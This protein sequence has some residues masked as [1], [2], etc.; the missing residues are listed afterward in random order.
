MVGFVAEKATARKANQ[1][2]TGAIS[3][4]NSMLDSLLLN[5]DTLCHIDMGDNAQSQ[6]MTL[7]KYREE[8]QR[9]A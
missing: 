9:T 6:N 3:I 2:H 7:A 1:L 4:L 5:L 8:R